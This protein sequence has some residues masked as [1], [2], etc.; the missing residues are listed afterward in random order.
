MNS[1]ALLLSG[2][3]GVVRQHPVLEC[4]NGAHSMQMAQ[5]VFISSPG[6][7]ELRSL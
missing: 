3:V 5:T 1:V 7:P 4:E 6:G 2:A